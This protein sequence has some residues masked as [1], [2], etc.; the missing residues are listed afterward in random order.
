VR[1]LCFASVISFLLVACSDRGG[2]GIEIGPLFPEQPDEC[3][4][5]G[6]TCRGGIVFVCEADETA[7]S[8]SCPGLFGACCK[9]TPRTR[10][11]TPAA[12][13]APPPPPLQPAGR[14]D[15][16]VCASGCVCR[17]VGEED[18]TCVPY[19]DCG[20]GGLGD[21][22]DGGDGD[23]GLDDAGDGGAGDGGEDAGVADAGEDA[24]DGAVPQDE[25]CGYVSCAHPCR[26]ESFAFS[27]CDCSSTICAP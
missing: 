16:I 11:E 15:E 22:G 2:C 19:C 7:S 9:P 10:P 4:P 26:C 21:A 14:C 5:A 13:T 1:S 6:G 8:E 25:P 12:P 3:T 24:A 17:A 27:T 23:G 18:G 20:D